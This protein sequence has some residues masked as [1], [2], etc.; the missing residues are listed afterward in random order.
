MILQGYL[1]CQVMKFIHNVIH[2]TKNECEAASKVSLTGHYGH[3]YC[4]IQY[5]DMKVKL[6]LK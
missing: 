6:D 1:K 5:K 2:S 3:T 4:D